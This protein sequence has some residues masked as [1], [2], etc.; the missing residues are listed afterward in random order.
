MAAKIRIF[1]SWTESCDQN[2]KNHF[3]KKIFNENLVKVGE[4]A[5]NLHC[6]NKICKICFKTGAKCY[7]AKNANM[8][9]SVKTVQP[10]FKFFT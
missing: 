9:T 10:I 1:I 7:I 2:L 4:H 3:P 8:L 6:W 5:Y